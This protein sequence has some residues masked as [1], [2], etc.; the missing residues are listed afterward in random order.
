MTSC[1]SRWSIGLLI[2]LVILSGCGRS[3]EARKARHL[4][5]GAK[6]FSQ[7]Q[8]RE[9]I[10]EYRNAL[11]IDEAN[12]VAIRQMGLAA[13]HLGQAAE[14]FPLLRKS[15]ELNPEQLDVRVKLGALYLAAR[16]FDQASA[17]ATYVLQ[18]EPRNLE[19][20]LVLAGATQTPDEI[21]AMTRRL[22]EARASLGHATKLYLALGALY[23]RRQNLAPAERTFR[24]ALS[25]D[26]KSVEAHMALGDFYMMKQDV[27]QAEREYQAGAD[28]APMDS[29]ARMKL[30]D[31]YYRVAQ[32][33][34][35]A[36]R[37]LT[38]ISAKAPDFLLARRRLAE[39]TF[40]QARYDE[41][42][43][44]LDGLLKKNPSD[45]DGRV[46][47]GRVLLA[48]GQT[49]EAIPEFQQALKLEPR[50][51][52]IHYHVATAYLKAGNREQANAEIKQA[53]TIAPDL[54]DA[55]LR[56]AGLTVRSGAVRPAIEDLETFVAKR[57]NE[58]GAYAV[59]GSA[60]LANREPGKATEAYRRI[61]ALAPKDARGPYL[62][63]VALRAQRKRTEARQAFEASLSLA[64]G[65]VEP[66]SNFGTSTMAKKSTDGF[67]EQHDQTFAP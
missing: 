45:P 23:L 22:E 58:T 3:P 8:Y 35:D 32:E 40:A 43:Q 51:A 49:T 24:E 2:A 5:R 56:R 65:F 6:Y 31:C 48:K 26:P 44:A 27:A 52:E 13:F 62:L 10:I 11:Q 41:T 18:R 36:K 42:L 33:S 4:E 9:A 61:M 15:A 47:R 12:A 7:Q 38:E 25:K 39:I 60:Y 34:E 64:P 66:L 20:L 21:D 59:L 55:V 50:S 37:M 14:A 16:R 46:L 54:R 57:P 63:G 1:A 19:A 67:L 28:L 53:T 17:E 29:M 30:V